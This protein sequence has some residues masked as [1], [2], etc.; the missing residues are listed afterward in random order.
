MARGQ[1]IVAEDIHECGCLMAGY[2]NDDGTTCVNINYCPRHAA[3]DEMYEAL[4]GLGVP[5]LAAEC[6]CQHIETVGQVHTDECAAARY[7]I[8]SADGDKEVA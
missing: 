2:K 4:Q 3:A 7:A 8:A 5:R 6:F 1:W